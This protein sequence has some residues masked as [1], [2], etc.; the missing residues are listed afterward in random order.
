MASFEWPPEGGGSGGVTSINGETGA[1]TLV[2]G[3][4]IT[5]TPAG[6]N[7]TIAAAA[8][9]ITG[10]APTVV[11]DFLTWN[12]TGATTAVDLGV[13]LSTLAAHSI[14]ITTVPFTTGDDIERTVYLGPG[15]NAHTIGTSQ[16]VGIGYLAGMGGGASGG[17]NTYVGCEAG[18]GGDD[19]VGVGLFSLISTTGPATCNIAL[20]SAAGGNITSG[21]HNLILQGN[22]TAFT[23]T[24][25]T[26]SYNIIMGYQADVPAAGSSNLM[27]VNQITDA[28]FGSSGS[29]YSSA[30]PAAITFHGTLGLGTDIAGAAFNLAGG[31]GTGAGAGGAVNIQTA[32]A[33]STGT[34]VN[35][36]VTS[37]S[38]ASTGVV[39]IGAA[40]TTPEHALN[41][42]HS[43]GSGAGTLTNLPTSSGNPAGY[44]K[45]KING[46]DSYI[47]YWQ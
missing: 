33:G 20:G 38:V 7:I 25:T 37:L 16:N 36:L 24:L 12:D 44:V 43:T 8:G 13:N 34:S 46:T 29:G 41:T 23:E 35:A 26:G 19:N 39:T 9:G 15:I 40:S 28:Y 11:G 17:N 31:A 30:T 45:I 5:I 2:A 3:A 42:A 4:N 14:S 47:P 18:G 22:A 1:V 6:Q 21:K 10:T 32:P 27:I